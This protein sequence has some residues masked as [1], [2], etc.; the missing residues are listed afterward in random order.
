MRT[1]GDAQMWEGSDADVGDF[2][3][4]GSPRQNQLPLRTVAAS[5]R[6]FEFAYFTSY[7]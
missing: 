3:R 7:E 1:L 6:R 5:F 2:E 4:I